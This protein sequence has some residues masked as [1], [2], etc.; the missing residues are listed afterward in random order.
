MHRR[1]VVTVLLDEGEH[2]E[3]YKRL[4]GLVCSAGVAAWQVDRRFGEEETFGHD[5]GEGPAD[6]AVRELDLAV[7]R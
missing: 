1:L 2:E 7:A 5:P 3:L 6:V 4:A